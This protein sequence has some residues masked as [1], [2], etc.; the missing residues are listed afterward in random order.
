MYGS[1]VNDLRLTLGMKQLLNIS[2]YITGIVG[3]IAIMYGAFRMYD[4]IIDNQAEQ[5]QTLE[6]INT[7]QTFMADDILDIKDTVLGIERKVDGNTKKLGDLER[8]GKFY[9]KNQEKY[10]T[11]QL[12]EI[13]DEIL[14][15]NGDLTVSTETLSSDPG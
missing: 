10:T 6:Y 11:E 15:K 1:I 8:A 12:Q 14:K 13:M 3:S 5:Q 4:N 9:L 2:K 7:E